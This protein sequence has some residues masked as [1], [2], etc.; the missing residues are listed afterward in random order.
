M[1]SRKGGYGRDGNPWRV[2]YSP[3]DVSWKLAM[4]EQI[5]VG[6][7]KSRA[8]GLHEVSSLLALTPSSSME[9]SVRERLMATKGGDQRVRE[10]G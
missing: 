4:T 6:G 1:K 8:K 9:R 5:R 10:K 3:E 2:E 7:K